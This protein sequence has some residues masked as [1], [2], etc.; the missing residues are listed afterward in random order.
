[1]TR[2]FICAPAALVNTL[3]TDDRMLLKQPSGVALSRPLPIPV[4][5]RRHPVGSVTSLYLAGRQIIAV[6]F[7]FG[8]APNASDLAGLAPE[9]DCDEAE[10]E[11]YGRGVSVLHSWRIC[12]ITLGHNPVWP[13]CAFEE[14]T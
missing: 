1:V 3:T 11:N 2:E 5:W 12:A 14:K 9:I 13:E 7:L 4:L 10:I 8:T 6:G